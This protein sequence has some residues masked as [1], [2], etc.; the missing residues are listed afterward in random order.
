M[1][2][3]EVLCAAEKAAGNPETIS[4]IRYWTNV[5]GKLYGED[6][7]TYDPF[8]ELDKT[9]RA[10]LNRRISVYA[11]SRMFR[12]F[13]LDP[14]IRRPDSL[15]ISK[16][17][18]ILKD[19]PP[20]CFNDIWQEIQYFIGDISLF[21]AVGS[22][23]YEVEFPLLEKMSGYYA[24]QEEIE[25]MEEEVDEIMGLEAIPLLEDCADAEEIRDVCSE[26][27][28][29]L[30]HQSG[31]SLIIERMLVYKQLAEA[32]IPEEEEKLREKILWHR[33]SVLLE[34][35]C[36]SS[37]V[38]TVPVTLTTT[39]YDNEDNGIFY[40]RDTTRLD[41]VELGFRFLA[42]L[43]LEYAKR[44]FVHREQDAAEVRVHERR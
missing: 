15:D 40:P 17:P 6:A 44:N 39:N 43:F 11:V 18:V 33:L 14:G 36:E 1:E 12:E 2:Y 32:E 35:W 9:L 28:E 25:L 7:L 24:S 26:V 19:E 34:P 20:R 3:R 23:T 41:V 38:S 27:K 13:G 29:V 4:R 5:M 42:L 16:V 21:D 10:L 22:D 30:V 31:I 37:F 8:S